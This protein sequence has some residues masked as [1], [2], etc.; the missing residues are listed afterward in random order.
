MAEYFHKRVFGRQD[1]RS[2]I[3]VDRIGSWDSPRYS[4]FGFWRWSGG[5]GFTL[6]YR[7][8]LLMVRFAAYG[9]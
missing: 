5:R 4:R 1:G 7:S 6:R 2:R 9:D 8:W 3:N